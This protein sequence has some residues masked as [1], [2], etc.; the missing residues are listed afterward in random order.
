MTETADILFPN[1]DLLYVNILSVI[2]IGL[3]GVVIP[4]AA[5]QC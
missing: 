2:S 4:T 3:R 5:Y 1:Y